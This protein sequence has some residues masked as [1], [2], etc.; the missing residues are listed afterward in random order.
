MILSHIQKE[1]VRTHTVTERWFNLHVVT[2]ACRYWYQQKGKHISSRT[3]YQHDVI[4]RVTSSDRRNVTFCQFQTSDPELTKTNQ[5]CVTRFWCKPTQ[6]PAGPDDV[7]DDWKEN[8]GEKLFKDIWLFS[9][10][11]PDVTDN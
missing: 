3:F 8:T 2:P 9:E 7:D 5:W 4:W 6:W 11:Q 1:A 10:W